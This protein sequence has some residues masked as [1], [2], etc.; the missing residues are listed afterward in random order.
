MLPSK[1]VP[2]GFLFVCLFQRSLRKL[3]ASPVAQ[4]VKNPPAG[5]VSQVQFLGWEDPLEKGMATYSSILAQR[6]P[7]IEELDGLYSPWVRKDSDTT[8]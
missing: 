4:T 6:I 2:S 1:S 7:W 8:E 3:W 5:Q